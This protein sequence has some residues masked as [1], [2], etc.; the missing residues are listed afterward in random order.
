MSPS[1]DMAVIGAHLPEHTIGFRYHEE[2][3]EIRLGK[4]FT[5]LILKIR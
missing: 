3:T 5:R 1:L 2:S 4:R